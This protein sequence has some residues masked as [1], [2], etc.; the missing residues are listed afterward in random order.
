MNRSDSAEPGKG[1][2][3]GQIVVLAAA[4]LAVALVPL[5]FA[6]LQL[7]YHDDIRAGTG[8]PPAQQAESTL[9]RS[10]HDVAREMP[11][12]YRWAERSAAV[13]AVHEGL[14]PTVRAITAAGLRRDRAYTVEYNRT[15]ARHWAD[16]NCPGGPERQFGRCVADRG[17]VVQEREGRTHV[18]AVAVDLRITTPDR[19]VSVSTTTRV[20]AG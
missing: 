9:E 13:T 17:V 10:V 19:T 6:Y 3:R 11:A 12:E 1:P 15:R 16:S 4:A 7:G 5:M 8:M 2:E 18:L 20:W 14:E